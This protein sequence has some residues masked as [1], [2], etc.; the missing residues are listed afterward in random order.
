[1]RIWLCATLFA[2]FVG[3]SF[4]Q[5]SSVVVSEFILSG[6]F[7]TKPRIIYREILFQKGDTLTKAELQE[8][9]EQSQRNL[10]NTRLFN[11]V[12]ITA[13]PISSEEVVL[14]VVMEERWYIFPS[15][16]FELAETNFNTWWRK[17]D[18]SRT[19]YG[20]FVD[21]KNFRGLR[22]NLYI[23]LRFG[24]SEEFRLY[25]RFPYF[26]KQQT[27][28]M[29]ISFDYFQQKEITIGTQNSERQFISRGDDNMFQEYQY[30]LQGFYRKSI[31]TEH[32]V[33]LRLSNTIIADTVAKAAPN[34]LINNATRADHLSFIYSLKKDHRDIKAYPLKGYLIE[35]LLRKTGFGLLNNNF[36]GLTYLN[37]RYKKYFQHNERWFS[38]VSLGQ[39]LS[40]FNREPYYSQRGLGYGDFVRGYEY[41]VIDAQQFS[42]IKT[43][44]KFQLIKQRVTRLKFLKVEQF[45]KIP[46]KVFLN[47]YADAAYT[48]DHIYRNKQNM[49]NT[50][51][52]GIGL[53]L[54]LVTYYDKV[55]R[56]EV[57]RNHLNEYGFYMHFKQPL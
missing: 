6:N 26:N 20:G 45:N 19:N 27:L 44:L 49:S 10:F 22:D 36:D 48:V 16:I 51:L 42:L 5:D 18:F 54:D 21:W 53:G 24:Y 29:G 43:N 1:M 3:N 39:K 38:G 30:K 37:L 46:F 56:L 35:A 7:K 33:E 15:P 28:G 32:L 40:F 13:V 23:K 11:F 2:L 9:I 12:T 4:G 47:L 17:K 25:Y 52:T 31:F 57:S 34:Y 55:I 14:Q 41:Y 50:W 8:K